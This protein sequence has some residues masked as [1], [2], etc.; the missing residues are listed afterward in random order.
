MQMATSLAFATG[1]EHP[2]R[3]TTTLTTRSHSYGGP[4]RR[5]NGLDGVDVMAFDEVSSG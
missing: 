2:L 1:R 5:A 4:L 3:S